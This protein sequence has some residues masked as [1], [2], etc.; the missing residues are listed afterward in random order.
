MGLIFQELVYS[1]SLDG[2]RGIEARD[3]AH[4]SE[5][6][7]GLG[8][9]LPIDFQEGHLAVQAF[10]AG[11]ELRPVCMLHSVVFK[12]NLSQAERVSGR[13]SGA[14][15]EVKIVQFIFWHLSWKILVHAE[16][17]STYN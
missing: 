16:T 4:V 7:H 14:A 10:I 6:R 1:K 3:L 12:R 2:V 13:F 11:F 15:V 5:D 17:I 8:V 9:G